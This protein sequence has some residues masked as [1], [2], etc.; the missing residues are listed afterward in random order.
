MATDNKFH[1]LIE[2]AVAQSFSG[3]DFSFVE[4]R[5]TEAPVSWDYHTLVEQRLRSANAVLDMCTGGGEFLDSFGVLPGTTVATEGFAPNVAIARERLKRRGI[6][7][8][9]FETDHQLPLPDNTFDLVINRHG[10][11]SQPELLRIMR[12]GGIFLTQ[13]V[14]SA[15]ATGINEALNAQPPQ[16]SD[17]RLSDAEGL[18]I[19]G[20]FSISRREEEFPAMVFRDIGAVVFYLKA[21][22]WQIP[23]FEPAK[24][25][26][27]LRHLHDR[28]EVDGLFEV[29]AHRFLL[30]AIR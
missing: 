11:F 8:V 15:N 21:I 3:W 10:A 25:L 29:K 19:A 9:P 5:L 17:W 12:S 18:L 20:G 6:E 4:G 7:V 16:H 1:R 2:Q 30:E 23:D 13:Q 22:P 28:I 14:G 26:E 24:Y 27:G